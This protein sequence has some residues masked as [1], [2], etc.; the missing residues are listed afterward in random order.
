MQIWLVE[1]SPTFCL[2]TN[3]LWSKLYE[4]QQRERYT[5]I[6]VFPLPVFRYASLLA[7]W[8]AGENSVADREAGEVGGFMQIEF[9]HDVAPMHLDSG[10]GDA[11]PIRNHR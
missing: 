7:N 1:R 4:R 10:D 3:L 5:P 9:A 8:L 6:R 11:Q 2:L